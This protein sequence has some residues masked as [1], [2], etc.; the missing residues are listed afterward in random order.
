M[1]LEFAS[2]Q[3]LL[4]KMG[5]TLLHFVWQ[6]GITAILL[7]ILLFAL[8]NRSPN[9]RYL[10][11]CL[12]LLI[13]FF[14]PA[15]TF[16]LKPAPSS[17]YNSLTLRAP[18]LQALPISLLKKSV[19]MDSRLRG[20]D[21]IN[22]I[23]LTSSFPRRRESMEPGYISDV[24]APSASSIPSV[25]VPANV[26]S[27]TPLS[28]S[29]PTSVTPWLPWLTALWLLGVLLLSLRNVVG[30]MV[31]QRLKRRIV[32]P[33]TDQM[34]WLCTSI[35]KRMG[36]SRVVR[37][38]ES[39]WV[40]NPLTIGWLRP[41]ILLPAGVLT[42]LSPMQ[43][44]AILA[45]ELAHIR[46]YDYL[47]NL[48]QVMTETLLFYHPAVWW[49]SKRIREER[50]HCCDDVAVE[51]CGDRLAYANAL[52]DLESLR[53]RD[54]AFALAATG[55]QLLPRVRRVL[56]VSGPA[57]KEA[58]WVAVITLFLVLSMAVWIGC[59]SN[60]ES[61]PEDHADMESKSEAWAANASVEELIQKIHADEVWI[62]NATGVLIGAVSTQT[63]PAEV[64][65][66]WKERHER[67]KAHLPEVQREVIDDRLI[68][69]EE[70][71]EGWDSSRYVSRR[72][73]KGT[74][75]I[76]KVFVNG[77]YY[78]RN[79][80]RLETKDTLRME[81]ST[82]AIADS[83][84]SMFSFGLMTDVTAWWGKGKARKCQ[85]PMAPLANFIDEGIK[86]RDGQKYRVLR[87]LLPSHHE[88]WIRLDS[89]HL[90]FL[91]AYTRAK[92]EAI[93]DEEI[94]D[95]IFWWECLAEK[96]FN[97]WGGRATK[98]ALIDFTNSM[99]DQ[100][101]RIWPSKD[102]LTR[103]RDKYHIPVPSLSSD[104]VVGTSHEAT[105]FAMVDILED[106]QLLKNSPDELKALIHARF[107]ED[108]LWVDKIESFHEYALQDWREVSPGV[109][110]PYNQKCKWFS[111]SVYPLHTLEFAKTIKVNELHLNEPL[112]DSLFT[113]LANYAE[114]SS[115]PTSVSNPTWSKYHKLKIPPKPFKASGW[116]RNSSGT[117]I[118]SA[119]V[120]LH[121]SKGYMNP[122]L[123]VE[124]T[125]T[126]PTG[127]FTFTNPVDFTLNPKYV[128]QIVAAHP[129][130]AIGWRVIPRKDWTEDM[131]VTLTSPRTEEVTVHDDGGRP[132]EGVR[133]WL[134]GAGD[135]D[136]TDPSLKEYLLLN[137][138]V[139]L[140]GAATDA[141]GK[142]L[143]KNVPNT[144][145][146]YYAYKPG[147]AQHGGC[148]AG[149]RIPLS[150]GGNL[151]GQ[152]LNEKE[153][154]VPG[155]TVQLS[156]DW[157]LHFMPRVVTG[158]NGRY[159]FT[160]LPARGWDMS[161]WGET[162][163]ATG[164]YKVTLVC[165]NCI[166]SATYVTLEPATTVDNFNMHVTTGT[167][168]SGQVLDPLPKNL[169][170]ERILNSPTIIEIQ[171]SSRIPRESFLC[172]LFQV[173]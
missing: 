12:C 28:V 166:S 170:R 122:E 90:G 73:E 58:G 160:D 151:A 57:S 165:S 164:R 46:R 3:P 129:D 66:N 97:T 91:K 85:M 133:V 21:G 127:Y 121:L 98:A 19:T 154:P 37:V 6:G 86:E 70:M 27:T 65:Q 53:S 137:M 152:V 78:E 115:V 105:L 18:I 20:N 1:I 22:E 114:K 134:C 64:V 11:G 102:T 118:A 149:T 52:A 76:E 13:L 75:I 167:V 36:I 150:P 144:K 44:E 108:P 60:S 30:W 83:A 113:E 61:N 155:A 33:V 2:I 130:Y 123:I 25:P 128:Y 5:W 45:H 138:D 77:R 163:N 17:R 161:P 162:T 62:W 111:Y 141:E 48:F 14:L 9:T 94:I 56:G 93:F 49:V 79:R 67:L 119:E 88:Y 69:T 101:P 109:F 156:A 35:T 63:V 55:E 7:Q 96:V 84:L 39:G 71:I 80:N 159:R 23:Q 131:V 72:E 124:K 142:A 41:L 120:Y 89:G 106:D 24:M 59:V 92:P 107:V 147:F 54:C 68:H 117:P 153:L 143:V 157:G 100:W 110:Y 140:T 172:A 50:E 104:A 81:E 171:R 116:V 169:N 87:H 29:L 135:P 43:L 158:D 136:S 40:D 173:R 146:T 34:Q 42:G 95:S 99:K 148:A 38:L 126:D 103:Y 145:C 82:D 10:A 26:I 47:V 51:I 4:E 74:S 139:G 8:K 112:P 31:V 132:V 125:Q 32:K 15:T 16:L 168:I